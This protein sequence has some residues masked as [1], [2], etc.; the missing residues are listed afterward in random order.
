MN[1]TRNSL[2]ITEPVAEGRRLTMFFG[3]MDAIPTAALFVGRAW[4]PIL[5]DRA[6]LTASVIQGWNENHK[7]DTRVSTSVEPIERG[8]RLEMGTGYIDG[9][10]MAALFVDG[11]DQ[12]VFI[13]RDDLITCVAKGNGQQQLG[14]R[15]PQH[16]GRVTH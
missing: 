10:P 14:P 16:N 13:G 11:S 5:I 1:T 8:R 4:Q 2:E 12:P 9:I 6:F 7:D 15:R 3:Y